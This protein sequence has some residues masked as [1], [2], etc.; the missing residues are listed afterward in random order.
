MR[1]GNR[2]SMVYRICIF[3]LN[4]FF[5]L[6]CGVCGKEDYYSRHTALC[7]PCIRKA[8]PKRRGPRCRVCSNLLPESGLCSFCDSRNVFFDRAL[9]IHDRSDILSL[10]LNRLKTRQE[11]SLSFFLGLGSKKVLR[12][13]RSEPWEAYCLLPSHQK[14]GWLGSKNRPFR[15]TER[16]SDIVSNTL[17]IP[18]IRPLHKKS[19]DKQ[20]GKSYAERFFHAHE[21]WEIREEWKGVCP[22]RILLLDDVFTTGASVNEASRILKR[23]GAEKV[24]VLTYLRTLD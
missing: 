8:G 24:Y 7:G 13:I 1:C 21:A 19:K 18:E 16:L 5:P 12:S 9:S 4:L 2:V 14:R 15:P 10:A 6:T 3:L 23:N 20:A 17:K 22:K 11:Y